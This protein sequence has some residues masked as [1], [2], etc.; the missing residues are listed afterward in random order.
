MKIF[1]CPCACGQKGRHAGEAKTLR[2]VEKL[3]DLES[4][5]L[6]RLTRT[7]GVECLDELSA[8]ADVWALNESSSL[9]EDGLFSKVRPAVVHI[10][11]SDSP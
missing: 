11:P 9:R 10:M 7:H 6:G 3:R 8:Y 5:A 2:H 4:L 1:G